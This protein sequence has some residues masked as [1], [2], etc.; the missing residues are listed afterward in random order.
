MQPGKHHNN[1]VV[2][3][4]QNQIAIPDGL[5]LIGNGNCIT[6]Q[7]IVMY[8]MHGSNIMLY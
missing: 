8:V 5:N 3:P 1:Y 7:I 6:K 4:S 2:D